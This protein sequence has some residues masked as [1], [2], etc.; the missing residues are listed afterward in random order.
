MA[1]N[2]LPIR[3]IRMYQ[4]GKSYFEHHGQIDGTQLIEMSL[5]QEDLNPILRSL[6]AVV[7][8]DN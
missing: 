4:H 3:K 2:S 7:I 6:S 1:L 8:S 5:H